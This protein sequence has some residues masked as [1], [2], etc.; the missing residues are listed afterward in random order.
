MRVVFWNVNMTSCGA[1]SEKTTSGT[2]LCRA[3]TGH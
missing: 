1:V 3:T 2:P